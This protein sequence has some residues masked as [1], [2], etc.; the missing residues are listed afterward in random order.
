VDQF[1]AP[2]PIRVLID[3][4]GRDLTEERD[5]LSLAG[6]CEDAEIHQFLE[7][8]EFNPALLNQLAV[9]ATRTAE[10]RAQTL[11]KAAEQKAQDVLSADLK[12]L[13]DL[14]VVN[15]HVRPE[16]ISL[17]QEQIDRTRS[18]I[19]QARV[20][21]DSLRLVVEGPDEL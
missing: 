4:R 19:S 12:R 17:A 5:A 11:K 8:P 9:I 16:E 7:R 20:R 1:L 14:S 2:T 18:A 6:E 15:D 13:V 10:V 3:L 21:L